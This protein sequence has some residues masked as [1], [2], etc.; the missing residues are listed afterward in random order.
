MQDKLAT[1][2]YWHRNGQ[3]ELAAT[4]Y[5]EILVQAPNNSDA[6][7]L[8]GAA[9]QSMGR[10]AEAVEPFR[11][12]AQVQ[13]NNAQV[14]TRL[15]G[16]LR[17]L[18]RAEEALFH[19]QRAA[20]L[21]PNDAVV[22]INLGQMLLSLDRPEEAVPPC[23]EAVRLQPGRATLHLVLADALRWAG[24]F[25]AARL[26]YLRAIELQPTLAQAHANLGLL[27]RALKN[28]LEAFA[29]FQ[30]AVA[31]EPNNA[32]F[33]KYLAKTHGD[34]TDF[35]AAIPC[36]QRAIEL[37]PGQAAHH[38]GLSEALR[39]TGRFAEAEEHIRTAMSLQ[40]NSAAAHFGLAC[41]YEQLNDKLQAEA[42]FRAASRLQPDF[43]LARERLVRLLRGRL[44]DADRVAIEERLADPSLNDECRIKLLFRAVHCSRCS[45]RLQPRRPHVPSRPRLE[46]R[47]ARRRGWEYD[48][49]QQR[50]IVD[51]MIHAFGPNFFKR[52]A[53]GG[54]LTQR[55]VFI[56]GLPRSG[57]TLIEQ[58]LASHRRV[59]GAGELGLTMQT[60]LAIPEVLG[61][62]GDPLA[63]ASA[64]EPAAIRQLA[65][66]HLARL[67]A[68]DG[69]LAERIIDKMPDN[70]QYLGLLAALFP[71]A[72]I[73]HCRR[74]L[75]DV[76]VSCWLT[77]F[78][79]LRWTHDFGHIA[80]RFEQYKRLMEHWQRV[81]PMTMHEVIYEEVVDNLE[82]TARR[83]VAACE[84]DWDPACLEFHRTRRP[85]R[86]ASAAQVRTPLYQQSVGRWKHYERDLADLLAR[87]P[88]RA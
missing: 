80:E 61:R 86:T 51:Q 71:R 37:Q 21:A 19:F 55:P 59:H 53:G 81:L 68:W 82:G 63:C 83:L 54:V 7:H 88:H 32:S 1:A 5:R 22:Q 31:L 79:W 41:L 46:F 74:D 39:E 84:L 35:A 11:R 43:T 64:L 69:G 4:L 27:F 16:I 72:T 50:R 62:E 66:R 34:W 77:H 29:P 78:G 3:F 6:L 15:G 76:A 44:P 36:W 75:R 38:L 12:A 18:G 14:H 57:T 52:T 60:C 65:E 47:R 10:V 24:Q 58:I 40:P 9:L 73:I 56:V 26:S 87:L 48:P 33:W 67:A 28:T 13:P 25:D 42:A 30:R 49:G 70:Y 45:R 2:L 85:V 8:L 23:R 20:E 17:Q